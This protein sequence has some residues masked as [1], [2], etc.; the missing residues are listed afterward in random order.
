LNIS[1]DTREVTAP[2]IYF[3]QSKGS[4][5]FF[6]SEVTLTLLLPLSP[7]PQALKTNRYVTQEKTKIT[8]PHTALYKML[9]V[10]LFAITLN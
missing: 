4:L 7:S 10:A 9:V 6:T 1:S 5:S 8:W 2:E 3:W